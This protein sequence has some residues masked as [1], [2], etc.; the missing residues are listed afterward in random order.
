L[1]W[2]GFKKEGSFDILPF[3]QCGERAD[4]LAAVN[5]TWDDSPF[6]SGPTGIAVKTVNLT[7]FKRWFQ[8]PRYGPWKKEALKHG[9]K[10]SAAFPLIIRTM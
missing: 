7:L 9:F 1:A 8:D 4:Y 3:V 10:A 6:G 2:V 5:I